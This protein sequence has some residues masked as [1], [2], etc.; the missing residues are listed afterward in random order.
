MAGYGV[1]YPGEV[2]GVWGIVSRGSARGMGH[3]TQG[4]C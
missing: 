3:C 1:L 4:K 2:L